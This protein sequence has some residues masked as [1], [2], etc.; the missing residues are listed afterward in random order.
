MEANKLHFDGDFNEAIKKYRLLIPHLIK[1][2]KSP[3]RQ[4][5]LASTYV[6]LGNSYKE[7]HEF[8]KAKKYFNNSL[9][10]FKDLNDQN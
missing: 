8:S 4:F 10:I 6:N 9:E 1:L 7:I 5:N 3:D 2:P